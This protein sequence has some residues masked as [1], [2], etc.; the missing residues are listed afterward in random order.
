MRRSRS[1]PVSFIALVLQ[2]AWAGSS[3]LQAQRSRAAPRLGEVRVVDLGPRQVGQLAVDGSGNVRVACMD[4][5]LRIDLAGDVWAQPVVDLAVFGQSVPGAHA[6]SSDGT[7][8]AGS[9]QSD[10]ALYFEAMWWDAHAPSVA[11]GLGGDISVVFAVENTPSGRVM[12]GHFDGQPFDSRP[13]G[14]GFL[15][16]LPSSQSGTA[17]ALSADGSVYCGWVTSG[18]TYTAVRW[19]D[20]IPEALDQ[21]TQSEA[22]GVSPSGANF[23]GENGGHPVLWLAQDGLVLRTL[24]DHD[25]VPFGGAAEGVLDDGFAFGWG[26]RNSVRF[27]WVWHPSYGTDAVMRFDDWLA[28]WNVRPIHVEGVQDVHATKRSFHFVLDGGPV[29]NSWYVQTPKDP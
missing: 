15:P 21:G 13:Q 2:L 17:R 28:R 23:A 1:I 26:S 10:A 20:R 7:I 3:L 24:L 12:V 14:G 16:T 19:V 18:F 8:L 11:H 9:G 5:V 4:E 29:Q 22:F 25:G 27:G 6:I